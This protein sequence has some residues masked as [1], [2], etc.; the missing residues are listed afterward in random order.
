MPEILMPAVAEL[1]E[2]FFSAMADEE[3]NRGVE[4]VS[5]EFS[6]RPTPLTTASRFAGSGKD[7]ILELKRENKELKEKLEGK[8]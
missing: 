2:G 4:R 1:E 5:R 8:R 7:M 6:G 3:F